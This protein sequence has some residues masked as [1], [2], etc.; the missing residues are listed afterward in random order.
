MIIVAGYPLLYHSLLWLKQSGIKEAVISCGYRNEVIRQYFQDGSSLG[1]QISY[2][3]EERPL[4][5]G[6]GVKLAS[7]SW[8]S[9]CERVLVMNG[10]IVTNLPL[11]QL[12]E[13]HLEAQ[14][15]ATIVTAP[16]RSPYGIVECDQDNNVIRFA[17]KPVLPYWINAGVYLFEPEILSEFP[18]E[19]DH[20]ETL[21]PRLAQEHRL[22]SYNFTGF[23]RTID[24]AKELADLQ[25]ELDN[26]T[27]TGN[28]R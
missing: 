26:L 6:G 2:A 25:R 23:W 3:I 12:V 17:E 24:T 8:G 11:A 9:S 21:L 7:K 4:G 18:D 20:E 15:G 19:G 27:M 28:T 1:L 14:V 13:F 22:K 10:D 16:L 5:R